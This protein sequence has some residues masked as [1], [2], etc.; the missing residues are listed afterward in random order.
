MNK[1]PR[2]TQIY[3]VLPDG[4]G[5]AAGHE[6][7]P[8]LDQELIVCCLQQFN[9]GDQSSVRTRPELQILCN[10]VQSR[11]VAFVLEND[12]F[13]AKELGA[14]GVHFSLTGQSR[15]RDT[16]LPNF[17]HC[18]SVLDADPIIGSMTDGTKHQAMM[19]GEQAVSYLGF[20]K[21]YNGQNSTDFELMKWW[22]DNFVVPSVAFDINS[23]NDLDLALTYGADF[24][25]LEL[26][27][28]A[29]ISE[30]IEQAQHVAEKIENFFGS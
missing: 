27:R 25:S 8:I 18:L 20:C 14:D 4:D 12:L 3:L 2:K 26:A 24:V 6:L 17:E 15:D 23:D 21:S 13:L 16:A 22:N 29:N 1:S 9:D 5:I 11:D 19:I 7:E 10:F 28:D 30:A